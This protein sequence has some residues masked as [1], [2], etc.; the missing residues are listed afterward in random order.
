[1]IE[2]NCPKSKCLVWFN[3]FII[4]CFLTS[5]STVMVGHFDIDNFWLRIENFESK[6]QIQNIWFPKWELAISPQKIAI[7]WKPICNNWKWSVINDR[8]KMVIEWWF[9]G[10]LPQGS[11]K[12][13]QWAPNSKNPRQSLSFITEHFQFLKIG[14]QE[15][16]IFWQ[17]IA[18]SCSGNY[19]FQI[20]N[21][22]LKILNY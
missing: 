19:M 14:F 13:P 22:I 2:S 6:I 3:Y 18:N 10:N 12:F 11:S 21:F 4:F 7:S 1:M 15:M 5:Y 9:G 17:E 8:C 16:A 20:W